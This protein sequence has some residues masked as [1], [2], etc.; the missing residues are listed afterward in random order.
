MEWLPL[1][2][3]VDKAL[4]ALLKILPDFHTFFI[5]E[6]IICLRFTVSMPVLF[7]LR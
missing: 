5:F 6:A 7:W 3:A 1:V 2:W 4:Q